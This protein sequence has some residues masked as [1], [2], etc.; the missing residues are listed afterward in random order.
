MA[1]PIK[2]GL[3]YFSLDVGFFDDE[4]IVAI[5]DEF[6]CKGEVV[7]IRLLCAIYKDGA[8]IEFTD[9]LARVVAKKAGLSAGLVNDVVDRAVQYGFFDKS[10][11]DKYRVLTSRGI[12]NRYFEAKKKWQYASVPERFL[13]VDKNHEKG[14]A[15]EQELKNSTSE[16]F[17]QKN[18][19]QNGV[20]CKKTPQRKEKK[21]KVNI[22]PSADAEINTNTPC[23]RN[24]NAAAATE[25]QVNI[26]PYEGYSG[27]VDTYSPEV[28]ALCDEIAA[29]FNTFAL[30]VHLSL[31]QKLIL[32]LHRPGVDAIQMVRDGL[33][34][35]DSAMAIQS[36]KVKF[37]ITTFLKPEMFLRLYNGDYDTVYADAP[38]Q[39][40]FAPLPTSKRPIGEPKTDDCPF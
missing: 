19:H 35:Y 15:D 33:K 23:T 22:N 5:A 3:D 24:I 25:R 18:E 1:R 27:E 31:L 34:K 2:K 14:V 38:Y 12:Q 37:E 26:P 32:A 21:S 20:F 11:F 6:G 40:S 39:R 16:S 36:K 17:L 30:P 10:V 8:Y 9:L 7:I 29:K 4:K 13:L 28:R